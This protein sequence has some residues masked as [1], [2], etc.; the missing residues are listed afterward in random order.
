MR[1]LLIKIE[2]WRYMI[3]K[4]ICIRIIDMLIKEN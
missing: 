1:E 4:E 3:V 2:H